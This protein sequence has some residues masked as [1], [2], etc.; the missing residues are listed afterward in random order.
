MVDWLHG[1]GTAGGNETLVHKHARKVQGNVRFNQQRHRTPVELD[2]REI[3]S[4][5]N[6]GYQTS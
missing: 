4:H 6:V 2:V 5:I 3:L 1:E